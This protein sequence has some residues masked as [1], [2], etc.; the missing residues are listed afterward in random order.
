MSIQADV[1]YWAELLEGARIRVLCNPADELAV[2]LAVDEATV[3]GH[4]EVVSSPAVPLGTLYQLP[5]HVQRM[6]GQP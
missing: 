6:D 2:T 5:G 3:C 4:V 1:R